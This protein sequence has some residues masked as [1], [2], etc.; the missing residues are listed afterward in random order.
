MNIHKA[1]LRKAYNKSAQDRDASTMQAWKIK[2]RAKFLALL[3]KRQKNNLLEVG[4]GTGRDSVFFRNK[5][6]RFFA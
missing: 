5:V 4:A 2:E 3:Q 6:F 1:N